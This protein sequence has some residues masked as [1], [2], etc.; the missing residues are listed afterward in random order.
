MGFKITDAGYLWYCQKKGLGVSEI[1]EMN[2][3]GTNPKDC[4]RKFRPHS[5]FEAQKNW[6][7]ERINK[8]LGI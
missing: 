1:N 2:I 7:D 3:I 8:I 4:Y 5:T 6:R